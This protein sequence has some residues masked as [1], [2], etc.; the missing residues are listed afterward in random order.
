VLTGITDDLVSDAPLFEQVA[1]NIMNLLTG[2]IF[3]A[4][5]V[6]FDYSF[7]RHHLLLAGHHWEAPK[8][9]T[10][11]LSKKIFPGH[12]S[13]SLGN[14]SRAMGI[15]IK[16]RHRAMG[17]AEATASLFTMLVKADEGQH[18]SSMLKKGSRESYLPMHLP[19]TDVEQLPLLPGVYYFHD[20]KHKI[21]Y[22][23]KAKNLRKR[24]TSHFSNN[25]VSRKKQELIR[26]V[27]RISYN[28]TGSEFAAIVLESIEIRKH[29]P[30]YN[31][32]QK[33]MEFPFGLFSYEDMQGRRRLGIGRL[34]KNLRP[35]AKFGLLTDAHRALWKLVKAHRLCPGLCFLQS[36]GPCVGVHEGYCKGICDGKEDLHSYNLRVEQALAGLHDEQPSFAILEDG[37]ETGERT[38]ILMEEGRFYGLGFIPEHR[39][40]PAIEKLKGMI[41]PYPENE[42]IRSYIM[43]YAEK[44]PSRTRFWD[45][46]KSGAPSLP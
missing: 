37:R 40:L 9:C 16:A 23:G 41:T 14:I 3:V 17:D 46:R 8:L 42:F 35:L 29:W 20:N 10:V 26:N 2:R 18:I 7:I 21:I 1:A 33:Q 30:I 25:A 5:N 38:C 12:A 44:N 4:H 28:L 11:R 15:G 32:S 36:A 22:V 34:K 45:A 6:N 19:V 43:Q 13:Y 24:V 27:H 39:E 31:S